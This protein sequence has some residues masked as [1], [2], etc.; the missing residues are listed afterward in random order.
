VPS[1]IWAALV[2]ITVLCRSLDFQ[3]V[4]S[5]LLLPGWVVLSI[6]PLL[7]PAIIF[8]L[9]GGYA[10]VT[11][12][13]LTGLFAFAQFGLMLLPYYK[14][15]QTRSKWLLWLQVAIVIL[16]VLGIAVSI[17]YGCLKE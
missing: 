2:A 13:L 9:V 12:V 15:L 6:V 1:I 10:D 7:G 16:Y 14:F 4:C 11:N 17:A 3:A 5:A 8:T